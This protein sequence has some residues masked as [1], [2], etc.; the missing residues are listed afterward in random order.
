MPGSSPWI[1]CSINP[2]IFE[3]FLK[4]TLSQ[5]SHT[6][7]S[8][9]VDI[10]RW[11]PCLRWKIQ[12][13]VNVKSMNNDD[14][15]LNVFCLFDLFLRK[16]SGPCCWLVISNIHETGNNIMTHRC[17]GNWV[18]WGSRYILN[19]YGFVPYPLH[20]LC[21]HHVPYSNHHM[22]LVVFPFSARLISNIGEIIIFS[23]V[24]SCE[25]HIE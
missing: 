9:T 13:Y 24:K 21:F 20:P 7:P 10:Y 11:L 15:P 2:E 4:P 22:L 19:W 1:M 6:K 16:C 23:I 25:L 18:N 3:R 17:C 14:R 5:P 8:S 12:P